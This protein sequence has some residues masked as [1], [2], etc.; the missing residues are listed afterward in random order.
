[1]TPLGHRGAVG[2]GEAGADLLLAPAHQPA[3]LGG[4]HE[5]RVGLFLPVEQP[6][7]VVLVQVVDAAI[8]KLA[9]HAVH[10]VEHGTAVGGGDLRV[11]LG[12]KRLA[13]VVELLGRRRRPQVD[14]LVRG[15]RGSKGG[16]CQDASEQKCLL[17]KFP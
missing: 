16:G 2:G 12:G 5:D 8:G 3:V 6:D 11:I 4:A 10:Q 14:R 1:A 9:F 17:H 13:D 15:K 7:P